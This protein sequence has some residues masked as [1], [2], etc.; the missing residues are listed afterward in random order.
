MSIPSVMSEKTPGVAPPGV[1]TAFV[2]MFDILAVVSFEKQCSWR[3][4]FHGLGTRASC[5]FRENMIQEFGAIL[6]SK[7]SISP[8][9]VTMSGPQAVNR[10]LGEK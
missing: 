7:L 9:T 5:A 10:N 2:H 8:Q 4:T 6:R 3:V 1:F